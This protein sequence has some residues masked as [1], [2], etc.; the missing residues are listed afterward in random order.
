MLEI[1]IDIILC[2]IIVFGIV[3]G[4]KRGF[5][6]M[7]VRPVK[8]VAAFAIAIALCGAV[9]SAIVT[10]IIEAPI[11]NYVRDFLYENCSALTAENVNEELPTLIKIAAAVFGIDIGEI[12]TD[13]A[14]VVDAI[15]ENLTAP[16]ISVIS[17]IIAF[18]ALFIVAKILL[19]IAIWLVSLIF[20]KGVFGL[21]N[22][23]LGCVFGALA[24]VLAS[25]CLAVVLELVFHLP[26]FEGNELISAFEGGFVYKFFNTYNPIELL[27]SF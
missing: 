21:L 8:S 20:S 11:S 6:L 26:V 3:F 23:V 12:A 24:S 13:G 14:S 1:I 10:P 19:G 17:S 5:I 18:I 4:L 2:A 16:V 9:A 25:W 27:L 15:V 7:A 22:K